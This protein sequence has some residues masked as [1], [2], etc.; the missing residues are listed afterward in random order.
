MK[1]VLI[2]TYYWPP[3]GGPGVQRILKFCKY[4]PAFGYEPTVLTVD[5][6]EFVSTDHSFDD[7]V[8]GI[9]VYLAKGLSFFK[10]F[11]LLTRQSKVSSHQLSSQEG[12]SNLSKFSRWIRYQLIIPDGRIGWYWSAVKKGREILDMNQYDLIFSTSPPHSVHLVAKILAKKSD[13]PWVADFRDPWTDR[14]YYQENHR[15]KLITYFDSLLEKS[16]LRSSQHITVV[17]SGFQNLF[18]A[19]WPIRDKSAIIYNGFDPDD[20]GGIDKKVSNGENIRI[21]HI[22]SLAKSQ[23]PVGLIQSIRDYNL[24]NSDSNMILHCIG[25]IH[26]DIEATIKE[27]NLV[28]A[29]EKQPYIEHKKAIEFMAQFDF[30]FLVIP[31]CDKNNGIIPGKLFEYFASSS[32]IILIGS[33][34]SDAALL[35]QEAGYSHIYSKNE[36]IDFEIIRPKVHSESQILKYNRREQTKELSKI[37]DK[38]S[39]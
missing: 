32:E 24:S 21:G 30:L 14:F 16:V 7:D 12:E 9:K 29:F 27:Y 26:P 28:D 5:G 4:L 18:H 20:F 19:H 39:S 3:S 13:I 37:F 10:L 8:K 2:I 6:G 35:L 22:G 23:N 33:K 36:K 38:L 11:K 34:E 25:S 17:S 31:D 1:K 15:N